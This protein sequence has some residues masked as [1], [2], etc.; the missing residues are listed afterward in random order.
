MHA[1]LTPPLPMR[2]RAGRS[3]AFLAWGA[4]SLVIAGTANAAILYKSIGPN[5]VIQFSDVPPENGVIVEQRAVA[6]PS[7][8]GDAFGNPAATPADAFENPLQTV[9]DGSEFDTLL[10]RANAQVDL[11]EHALALARRS[12]WRELSGLHLESDARS[13]TDEERIDFYRKNL[14]IARANLIDTLRRRAQ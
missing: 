8:A 14:K 13:R 4:A 11:A 3:L 5:G 9:A 2:S 12:M 10:A 6:D 7:R 1:I